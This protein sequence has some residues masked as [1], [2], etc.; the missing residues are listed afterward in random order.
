MIISK[1][2]KWFL[3]H[4]HPLKIGH[5]ALIHSNNSI[6][7]GGSEIGDYFQTGHYVMVREKSVMGNHVSIG[8]YSDIQGN[9]KRG[10]YVFC[11][12]VR[13]IV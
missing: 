8:N 10:N 11:K 12:N 6:I 7:Y 5:N 13:S 4:G 9:V 2:N 3:F 1:Y